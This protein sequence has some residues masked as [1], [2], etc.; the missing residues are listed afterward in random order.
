MVLLVGC[1]V[2]FIVSRFCEILGL[3]PIANL[4]FITGT[5][6]LG[7]LIAYLFFRYSGNYPDVIQFI[8]FY[9]EIIWR[10]VSV[11]SM[12]ANLIHSNEC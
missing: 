4:A 10:F 11:Y 5:L 1:V 7:L 3:S 9:S 8:D 2:L 12:S 6:D